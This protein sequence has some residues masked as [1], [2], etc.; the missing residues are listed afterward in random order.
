MKEGVYNMAFKDNYF[1]IPRFFTDKF[2]KDYAG[3]PY[4][5][6]YLDI[7]HL[8][9]AVKINKILYDS[10][11]VDDIESILKSENERKISYKKLRGN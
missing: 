6:K 3:T 10:D 8:A 5:E 11:R 2:K 7:K 4:L 9:Q 1:G